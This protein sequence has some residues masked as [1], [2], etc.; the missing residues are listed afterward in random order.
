MSKLPIPKNFWIDFHPWA[1]G[2]TSH[3]PSHTT[4]DW[5]VPCTI[6]VSD[7]WC[8]L[9]SSLLSSRG[10]LIRGDNIPPPLRLSGPRHA[11]AVSIQHPGQRTSS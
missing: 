11:P 7:I 10:D 8:C 4:A 9:E 5:T 3:R 6:V 1:M 2:A